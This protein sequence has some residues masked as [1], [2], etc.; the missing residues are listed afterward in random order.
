MHHTLLRTLLKREAYVTSS[1]SA[2]L[3]QP[4]PVVVGRFKTTLPANLLIP[5]TYNLTYPPISHSH[6]SY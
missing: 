1:L 6:S 3:A 5:T 2:T 4:C